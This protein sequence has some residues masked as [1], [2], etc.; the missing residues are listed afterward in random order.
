M[1]VWPPMTAVAQPLDSR[2]TVIPRRAWPG[3]AN[4]LAWGIVVVGAVLRVARWI[5]WPARSLWLDEI[6]LAN[7]IVSRSLHALL[8]TPLNDW[9]AAPAGF[10]V[11][12]HL[13]VRLLGSGERALRLTS[14]LFGL[15]SLPLA[16]AVARRTLSPRA[17][18]VAITFFVFLGPLIYYSNEVKPY[19]CDVAFSLAI[20][21]VTL[22]LIERPNLGRAVSAGIVGAVGIFCSFP[23]VFVIAGAAVMLLPRLRDF[24]AARR[25][26]ITGVF[27]G[28]A[29]LCQ[30]FIFLLPFTRGDARP[31]LVAYWIAQDT[32]MPTAPTE[33]L[34]WFFKSLV[35]IAHSPG[36]MW[37][38]CPDA[39]VAALI[40]G[41]AIALRRRS[42][43]YILLAPLPFVLLASLLR[44]YPFGDRLA[45]FLVPQ[46]LMLMAAGLEA[47]WVN[48]SGKVAALVLGGLILL[49]SAQSAVFGLILPPGREETLPAYRWMARQWRAGDTIYLTP[50]AH[51]SLSY[52]RAQ[53][54]FPPGVDPMAVAHNEPNVTKAR[55]ILDDVG[56]MAGR[57]RVWV[58]VVHTDGFPID[59]SGIT[60]AAFD[61]IGRPITQH[62]EPGATIYL[63]DCSAPTR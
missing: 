27:W 16:L 13:A 21:L 58:V 59:V 33:A 41:A 43:L 46:F 17:A 8:F 47:L 5:H 61:A 18:I 55:E 20:T 24:S 30:Y 6:Y 38:A 49:P 48:F 9:Q 57:R 60:L 62:L 11:L 44:Q 29:G 4:A 51:Q 52:Y 35:A 14:L 45:L 42:T 54:H 39:A 15:A 37:L 2:R 34:I 10:L 32:F 26:C 28:A 25:I 36:A 56:H 19:S 1:L 50:F 3:S 7:S 22:R 31:Y 12:E 23:A 53:A 40:V 63:Y